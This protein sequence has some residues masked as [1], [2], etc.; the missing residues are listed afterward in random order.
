M[1]ANGRR[2][3]TMLFSAA[4]VIKSPVMQIVE[5]ITWVS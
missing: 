5:E 2:M 1:V 4:K 3:L